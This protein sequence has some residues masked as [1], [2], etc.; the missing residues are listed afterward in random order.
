VSFFELSCIA[1]SD[2]VRGQVEVDG[3]TLLKGDETD[4]GCAGYVH[5][6]SD[7]RMLWAGACV[8]SRPPGTIVGNDHQGSIK[9]KN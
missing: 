1:A 2:L 5:N 7:I 3:L 9:I 6:E 8:A 4:G